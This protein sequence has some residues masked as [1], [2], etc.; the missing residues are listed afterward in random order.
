MSDT[1][2]LL[3]RVIALLRHADHHSVILCDLLLLLLKRRSVSVGVY[4]RSLQ[5]HGQVVHLLQSRLMKALQ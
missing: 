3:Q 2:E 1:A 5:S 4:S